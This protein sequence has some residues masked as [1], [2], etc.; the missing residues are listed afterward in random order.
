MTHPIPIASNDSKLD[1]I[2]DKKFKNGYKY[3]QRNKTGHGWTK[4]IPR[5]HRDQL[6]YIWKLILDMKMELNKEIEL[7]NKVQTEILEIFNMSNKNLRGKFH[8]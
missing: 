1:E 7:M 5:E 8:Q 4:W 3:V 2:P 6:Y